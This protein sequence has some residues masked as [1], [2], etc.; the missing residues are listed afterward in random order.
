MRIPTSGPGIGLDISRL[1]IGRPLKP[2][3]AGRDEITAPEGLAALS[4]DALTSVAYGPQAIILVL[5][6]AGTGGLRLLLPIT[7]AIVALLAILVLSYT[8]VIDAYPGGGGAYAVSLENLGRGWA[9]LAA[10][11]LIIDY[12]L[13]VAVSV[14]AGIAALT[15]AFPVL[16]PHTVLLCLA[17]L[18]VIT[19]LNL[20]GVGESARAFLLPTFVFIVGLLAVIAVGLLH[21]LGPAVVRAPGSPGLGEALSVLLVLKAFSAGCSALTGVEA[22]ANG[23]PVF[24]EP[25]TVRAKRTEVLL[26]TILGVMLLGLAVLAHRFAV[27]PAAG[28]TALSQIMVHAVGRGWLYYVVSMAISVTL[29]LAANT[30]FG[31]L[32][33]LASLLARDNDL[34]HIFAVRG[35]RLVF[36]YGIWALAGLAAVLLWAVHGNTDALIPMFALGVFT[37]FTLAQSGLVVH[38]WRLRPPRWW[39][40]AGVNGVGTLASGLATLVFLAT[41]FAA[42]AWVVVLAVPGFILLFRRI[43]AYYARLASEIAVP[44]LPPPPTAEATLVIVPVRDIS[45]LTVDAISAARSFGD[46]VVAVT[47]A[48]AGV[49]NEGEPG[50]SGRLEG[51]WEQWHP[52]VRLVTLT[53]QYHSV[54]R[55]LLRFI[56]SVDRQAH[57]RVM[58][59]IPEL[60]PRTFWEQLLHNQLGLILALQ[61]RNRADVVVGLLPY[62]GPLGGEPGGAAAGGG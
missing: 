49:R 11:A 60:V 57:R 56:R 4:L 18:A 61:L 48:F 47:V 24:Q 38:W 54:V 25:R 23:V 7:V 2:G 40:R 1:L 22:I 6:A 19:V 17:V 50:A 33:V 12:V 55:P 10:A 29:A 34:P 8:Q 46:E 58:V 37:G 5:L 16:L 14:A 13:T 44:E 21:P 42:G 20:R 15:S 51:R 39:L 59:L 62:H 45:R 32:P 31:G 43:H 36:Q 53:S 27:V 30:S 26:G 3:E 28:A 52:N 9:R 35:D 41:K